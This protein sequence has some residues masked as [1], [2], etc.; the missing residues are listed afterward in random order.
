MKRGCTPRLPCEEGAACR[1][2]LPGGRCA[3]VI[4]NQ[5][6]HSLEEIAEL[7]G[8]GVSRSRVGQILHE[9]LRKLRAEAADDLAEF[10]RSE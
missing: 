3:L 9:A 6:E 5:G 1:F 7:L 8:E 10:L 2:S 4:A